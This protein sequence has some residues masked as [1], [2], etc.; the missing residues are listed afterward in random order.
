MSVEGRVALVTG[1]NRGIGRAICLSLAQGG[2]DVAVHFHSDAKGAEE[3]AAAVHKV[4][5]RAVALQANV[6]RRDEVEQMLQNCRDSLGPVDILVNNARQ[7]VKGRS[8]LE[9][10]WE[11]DYVPQVEVMLRGTFNC[12]QAVLPSMIDRGFGRII[13]IL[14][15]V[16]AER[17]ARTNSYGSIKSALLYFSQNLAT[18]M[19][20]H[21]ITVNMVSPGLTATQRP[22]LHSSDHTQQYIQQTPIGR[23]GTPEDVGDAVAYLASNEAGFVSGV[24]LAVSGA[25]VMF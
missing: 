4:G 18:E 17:R 10:T 19:G 14:S 13:N 7:L 24:N 3:V 6:S 8:F 22:I 16:L 23:L 1:G 21:G 20:E 12:C 5:R 9:L 15:T 2:A 25:K 11:D